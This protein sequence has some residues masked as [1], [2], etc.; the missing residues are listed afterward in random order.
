MRHCLDLHSFR[1]LLIAAPPCA[2]PA[3]L[4]LEQGVHH[5]RFPEATVT[6]HAV[7]GKG[8]PLGSSLNRRKKY[9][10]RG[11]SIFTQERPLR[12]TYN[13]DV[14][15]EARLHGL[16][17]HLLDDGVNPDV[18]QQ[19][20]PNAGVVRATVTLPSI[21]RQRVTHAVASAVA[22]AVAAD[23]HWAVTPDGYWDSTWGER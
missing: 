17:S 13:H 2:P 7:E 5:R 1:D 22:R 15:V 8:N 18:A 4:R 14:E 20:R 6:C 23:V 12:L 9:G 19:G 3:H 21:V 10:E 11:Y 16:L